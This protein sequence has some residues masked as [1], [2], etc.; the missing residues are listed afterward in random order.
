VSTPGCPQFDCAHLL[1]TFVPPLKLRRTRTGAGCR[2]AP[3]PLSGFWNAEW[4]GTTMK[5]QEPQP[6][7]RMKMLTLSKDTGCFKKRMDNT[8]KFQTSG[9]VSWG[10]LGQETTGN[11]GCDTTMGCYKQCKLCRWS[12][13]TNCRP[14]PAR[15]SFHNKTMGCILE[16]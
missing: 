10:R 16:K 13:T 14:K 3:F 15:A 4:L 12:Y 11:G 9:S 7:T 1:P 2:Y 5:Y 6:N 8:R